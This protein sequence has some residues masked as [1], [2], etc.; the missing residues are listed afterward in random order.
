MSRR[1]KTSTLATLDLTPVKDFDLDTG[2]RCHR[3]V[4]L[5][6]IMPDIKGHAYQTVLRCWLNS[7][8]MINNIKL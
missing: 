6:C 5:L 8:V 3:I 1:S 4:N 7:R 2:I